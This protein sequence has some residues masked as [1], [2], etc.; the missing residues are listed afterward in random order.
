MLPHFGRV[1]IIFGSIKPPPDCTH[2]Q[3]VYNCHLIEETVVLAYT[4]HMFK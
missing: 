1:N 2:Y 4:I 3:T